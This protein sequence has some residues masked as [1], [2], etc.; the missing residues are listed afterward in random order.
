MWVRARMATVIRGL[1][2]YRNGEV[3]VSRDDLMAAH[4]NDA[5]LSEHITQLLREARQ[6]PDPSTFIWLGLY[7]PT[8]AEM[9]VVAEELGLPYLQ[10]EDALNVRQRAKVES[11]NDEWFLLFKVLRYVEETSDV[12]T[13]QISMFVGDGFVVT[14]RYGGVG[15][16]VE[17][18]QRLERSPHLLEQG[19]L[20]VAYVVL[21]TIVDGYTYVADEIE[22]DI[23][24][25]Q[26]SVFSPVRSDDSESIYRLKREVLELKR[27]ISPLVP[28]AQSLIDPGSTIVPA[29]LKPYFRDIADH[30]FRVSD[31]VEGFDNLLGTLLSASTQRLDLQQNSDMRKIS[32]WV[33]IA[34][35][36]TMIAGIYG[37][38]FDNIPELHWEYGYFMVIGLMLTACGLMF[39]AFKRSGWL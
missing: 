21:D 2:F 32:A 14:V 37:M 36:P 30:V 12:E 11:N 3:V 20:S 16:L 13:G 9:A 28:V 35:V 6:D 34:A 10:V 18:R 27:A 15:E 24:M 7:Q 31:Q 38:N 4:S 19:A 25:I 26:E 17:A 39:R 23:D 1:G 22:R 33:A 5:D 8:P 29:E